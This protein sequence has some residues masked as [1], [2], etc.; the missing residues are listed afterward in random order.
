MTRILNPVSFWKS[1]ITGP[2]FISTWRTT[3]SS[4]TVTLPYEA[5]GTYSGTIDW[6]DG[7]TSNN[8]YTDRTHTYATAGDYVISITGVTTGF[9]FNNTGDKTKIRSIQSWGT[10]RLRNNGSYFSGCSNLNLSSVSD[11]LDLTGITS[12]SNMF[13][14]CSSLTSVNNINSWSTSAITN[15]RF[16]FSGDILFNQSLSFD[17][18]A[19]NDMTAM[20][21]GCG[22]L[23]STITFNTISVQS[24]V[25]MFN[26]CYLFNQPLSFNTGAVIDMSYMFQQCSTFNSVLTFTSTANVEDMTAMFN[27]CTAFDQPLVWNTGAVQNMS[28]M[29]N[30]ASA[31]KQNIGTWDISSVTDFSNFMAG[32]TPATWPTTYFDNL[33]CGWKLQIVQPGLTIHFGS[34]NYTN[35]TGG[36]CRTVLQSPPKN[37]TINSGPGV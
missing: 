28:A 2:S 7:T 12:L 10:L 35:L 31:F 19:V 30:S 9:R 32:K 23:N 14:G 36:P 33:L 11:T 13:T 21:N 5:A 18:G 1:V 25:F 26:N 27:V 17:T 6:G 20:F 24:M 4:E 15:T 8:S 22:V 16:M 29:F 3:T 37:W 34:A